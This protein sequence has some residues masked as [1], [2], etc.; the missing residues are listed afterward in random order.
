MP[1]TK[2]INF[3]SLK[4]EIVAAQQEMGLAVA[5][6]QL[7]KPTALDQSLIRRFGTSKATH[8]L[9]IVSSALRRELVLAVMRLWDRNKGT[10]RLGQISTIMQSSGFQVE[11]AKAVYADM[12]QIRDHLARDTNEAIVKIAFYTDGDGKSTIEYL[13]KLR[14]QF[15]AHTDVA[16]GIV[17]FPGHD[18]KK[19]ELFVRDTAKIIEI[20]LHLICRQADD[21]S[22]MNS[23]YEHYSNEFWARFI[24]AETSSPPIEPT[25]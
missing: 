15:L 16:A 21:F 22:Q 1:R 10:I 9:K 24:I 6:Y 8:G 2:M 20:L 11:L 25:L 19:I 18:E 12:P 23:V 7:W 5:F 3:A 17:H 13:R 4:T 14:H